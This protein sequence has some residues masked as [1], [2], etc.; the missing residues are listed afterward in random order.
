[1]S[2][3]RNDIQILKEVFQQQFDK[4]DKRFDLIDKRFEQIDKRFEEIDKKFEKLEQN[5]VGQFIAEIYEL[6]TPRDDF[7]NLEKRVLSLKK[8]IQNP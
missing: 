5:L 8:Q 3:T 7:N 2:L 4:I 1:M 6:Y